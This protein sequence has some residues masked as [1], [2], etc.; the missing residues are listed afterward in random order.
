MTQTLSS[1]K[2]EIYW[3]I[4]N[5][6]KNSLMS[7]S[8]LAILSL[9]WISNKWNKF[10]APE[11]YFSTWLLSLYIN[12]YFASNEQEPAYSIHKN[13]F[14][15]KW[16]TVTVTTAKMHHPLFHCTHIFCFTSIHILQALMNASDCNF[17]NMNDFNGIPL[18]H[19]H[20]KFKHHSET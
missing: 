14:Q 20:F 5:N 19:T 18:L 2:R 12:I 8:H 7:S 4:L 17:F 10:S 15:W 11:H 13:L 1:L 3:M 16:P 6:K 9:L